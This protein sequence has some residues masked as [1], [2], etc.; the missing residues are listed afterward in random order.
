[1]SAFIRSAIYRRDR[2][3]AA[4]IRSD[5]ATRFCTAVSG[6]LLTLIGVELDFHYPRELNN[7]IVEAHPHE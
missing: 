3:A 4:A 7:A 1:M 6:L 5:L 2:P